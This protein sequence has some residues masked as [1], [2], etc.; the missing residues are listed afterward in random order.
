M[1]PSQFIGY[2][3]L[4][5]SAITSLVGSRVINSVI[6]PSSSLSALPAINY[7][8]VGGREHNGIGE[9]NFTINSRASTADGAEILGD[10]I[11]HILNGSNGMGIFGAMNGFDAARLSLINIAGLIYEDSTGWYNYPVDIKMVYALDTVS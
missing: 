10:L 8:E 1:R 11:I 7:Y 2:T 9:K 4:Q 3:L 5:T 6:P